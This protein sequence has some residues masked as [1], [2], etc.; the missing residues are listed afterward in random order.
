MYI[1]YNSNFLPSPVPLYAKWCKGQIMP[2]S[3]DARS[4]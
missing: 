2:V 4:L 1:K 3:A